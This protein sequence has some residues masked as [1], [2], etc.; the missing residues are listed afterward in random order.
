MFRSLKENKYFHIGLTAFL[1]IVASIIVGFLFLK[2]G[3]IWDII[4]GL[5]KLLNP[6]I[7]GFV[8]AYLLNPV[9]KFFDKKVVSKWFK[10]A[11][12]K[13]INYIS[14][15]I[16]CL[17]FILIIVLLF[18]IIIPELLKSVEKLAVNAP[19]YIEE[20]K[21][22]LLLKLGDGELREV[23]IYN[24]EAI[25]NYI[26][27][28]I[29]TS[30]LPKIDGWLVALSTGVI[31]VIK[32]LFNILIG[33]VIAIYFLADKDNYVGGFKKIIYT[34]FPVRISNRIMENAR[35][36]D[37]IFG[38]FI[39]GRL[40]DGLVIG[41]I[42][43]LFLIIFG[44]PYALLIAVLVGITNTIPYFGPW[45]GGIPAVLLVLMDDPAK[46]LIFGIFIVVL[47]Q[48]DGNVIGPK[49]CGSRIGLKSF[50]VLASILF[51][52]GLFG[53]IG[54]LVGVPLFALIYGYL[55][56]QITMSLKKRDLPT[57]NE[58]YLNI[59]RINSK[60][61]KIVLKEDEK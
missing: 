34:I 56:H 36:T 52:G 8:F 4:V 20:I 46:A 16:T 35:H 31:G 42:T 7:I 15:L 19:R 40:L 32:T 13:T 41:V 18:S 12:K 29:N 54:M 9:V 23:I 61:N 10:K 6:F 60:T 27:N 22:Y 50:W 1:V 33:F 28:V 47:Q 3:V 30:L 14:I 44:Y 53:V 51:F 24:Y 58:D 2:I 43:F 17:L 59:E 49:L 55:D 45:F 37:D 38:N 26:N 25:N 5:I 57:K 11:D 48:I 39:V 21:N